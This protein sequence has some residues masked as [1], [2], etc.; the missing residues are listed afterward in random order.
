MLQAAQMI[1][2]GITTLDIPAEAKT[3]DM[4]ASMGIRFRGC[5]NG[6]NRST[7]QVEKALDRRLACELPMS[8]EPIP[9]P[10]NDIPD[11]RWQ[12]E[13]EHSQTQIEQ[14]QAVIDLQRNRS[15]GAPGSTN[16]EPKNMLWT[17]AM[18]DRMN[19]PA[20]PAPGA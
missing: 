14:I 9:E 11:A 8:L 6:L 1:A 19:Q 2:L 13:I 18:K 4:P 15:S 12:A 7:I 17:G 20:R 5:A 3:T 16:E 10:V